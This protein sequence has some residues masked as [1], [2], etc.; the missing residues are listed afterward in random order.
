MVAKVAVAPA[1]TP[2]QKAC[3]VKKTDQIEADR[4]TVKVD[5]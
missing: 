3:V 5:V 2:M 4:H 1:N